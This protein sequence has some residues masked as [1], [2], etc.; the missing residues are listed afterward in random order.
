[1]SEP[2]RSRIREYEDAAPARI[3]VLLITLF[4]LVAGI[5]GVATGSFTVDHFKPTVPPKSAPITVP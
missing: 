5:L 2:H 4:M 3:A 1:M